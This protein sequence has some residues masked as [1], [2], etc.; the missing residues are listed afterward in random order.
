MVKDL[1]IKYI[2]KHQLPPPGS[3]LIVGFSGGADSVVL[4]H[5]LHQLEYECIAA[6]C[7]FHLRGEESLRDE[8]FARSF[9]ESL[10]IPFCKIDFETK[11]FAS[12]NKISVEMAAR[13]LRYAW[14]GKLREENNAVA[15]A[16]GHHKDDNVETFLLNL[17]RGTGIKGLT[18]LRQQS[19]YIIR[20]LLCLSKEDILNYVQNERLNYVTDSSNL[21]DEFTRNKLR[22]QVLPLLK[23]I[24]P[25]IFNT[26]EETAQRLDQTCKIYHD[27]ITKAKKNVFNPVN[28]QIDIELLKTFPAPETLLYEILKEYGFNQATVK[29][30]FSSLNTQSGK[31]FYSTHYLLVKDRNSLLISEKNQRNEEKIFQIYEHEELIHHPVHAAWKIFP[32]SEDFQLERNRNVAYF[33]A[34]KLNF[35]LVIRKWEKGDRFVPF[36]INGTKKL[37]DYFNDKKISIIKKQEIWLLCNDKDII[38][39]IGYQTDNKYKITQTTKNVCRME[40]FF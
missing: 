6:H 15:I 12:D 30:I 37:S 13:E 36:G 16:V 40:V 7:N 23:T 34:D 1:V 8:H 21:Q 24:N 32:K 4:L 35:P 11:S 22:L 38:W 5:I 20:P 29:D 26:I 28:R 27:S 33:D 19:G 31:K 17:I 14:F 9:A 10:Q 25:S 3:K 18:G 2:Q 39:I